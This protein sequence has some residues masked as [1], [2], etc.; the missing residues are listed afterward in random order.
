MSQ[1]VINKK[2]KFIFDNLDEVIQKYPNLI[3]GRDTDHEYRENTYRFSKVGKRNLCVSADSLYLNKGDKEVEY[4]EK[5]L[6]RTIKKM[7]RSN[8]K[9]K[10]YNSIKLK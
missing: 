1:T 5:Y 2:R 6:E 7:L 3:Q 9:R 10:Y 8:R 4:V